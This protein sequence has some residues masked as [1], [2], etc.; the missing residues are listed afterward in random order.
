MA[1][2]LVSGIHFA[3]ELL[4]QPRKAEEHTAPTIGKVMLRENNRCPCVVLW[5]CSC[6]AAPGGTPART[7]SLKGEPLLSRVWEGRMNDKT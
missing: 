4:H 1:V 7:L 3:V 2:I 5:F 6:H